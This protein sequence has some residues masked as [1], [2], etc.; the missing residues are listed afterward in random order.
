MFQRNYHGDYHMK[1]ESCSTKAVFWDLGFAYAAGWLST[2]TGEHCPQHVTKDDF[3]HDY[4]MKCA[5]CGDIGLHTDLDEALDFG[6]WVAEGEQFC[7]NCK[8]Q[9]IK[10]G[11]DGE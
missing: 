7:E 6:W 4:N 5:Y 11:F 9:A 10:D 2:I 8:D 1:C 3:K